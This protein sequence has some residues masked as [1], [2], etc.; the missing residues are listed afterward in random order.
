MIDEPRLIDEKWKLAIDSME[1]EQRAL[2]NDH[3]A[4]LD[5]TGRFLAGISSVET[6]DRLCDAQVKRSCT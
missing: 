4:L 1:K 3:Q 5:V 2:R 6:V